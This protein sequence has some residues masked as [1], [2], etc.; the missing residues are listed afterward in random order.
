MFGDRLALATRYAAYL[1][2]TGVS[3]GLIGP[4]EVPRL[5]ERHLLNCAVLS[6]LLPPDVAVVDVGAGAGLPGIPVAVRRP[7]LAVTLVEPLLRRV[8]WLETVLADLDL[9]RVVVRRA[10]AEELAGELT[11][12][13]VTARAVAP[14][15][16]LVR[17]GAPLL[18]PGGQMLA[19]KGRS[20]QE[21]LDAH[22]SLLRRWDITGEVVRVGE[23]VLSE[24][25]IV[26]RLT[27]PDP[28]AVLGR[29][30]RAARRARARRRP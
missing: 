10:R 5:W 28:D 11:A 30:G 18:V 14:L 21:E 24:P 7:D 12:P 17:W 20:A 9:E 25:T 22:S 19:I 16:R 26:V 13:F 8:T 23:A 4:R 3:H 27:V 1:A 29:S 15:D 2:D 6:E